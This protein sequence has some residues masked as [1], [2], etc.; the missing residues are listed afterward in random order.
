MLFKE[1][2]L[3]MVL[4]VVGGIITES[5]SYFEPLG[6]FSDAIAAIVSGAV[7]R[8]FIEYVH[9][10]CYISAATG[11]LIWL[12]PGN[13]PVLGG[14]GAMKM[15]NM[16]INKREREERERERERVFGIVSVK[17]IGEKKSQIIIISVLLSDRNEFY[18]G[19]Y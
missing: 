17:T 18:I 11:S 12:V 9:P 16:K 7:I 2:F 14:R 4:G 13:V 15:K 10:A 3:A 8:L 5:A 1:F 19:S 6:M